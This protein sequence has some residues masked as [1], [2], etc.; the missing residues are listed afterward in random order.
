LQILTGHTDSITV[1]SIT[2]DGQRA[3]T[4]SSDKT[5]VLWDLG[6]GKKLACFIS[7]SFICIVKIY[8]KGL[9]LGYSSGE[10]V[11]L[12]ADKN[13]FCYGT[14]ITTARQIWDFELQKY[15]KLSAD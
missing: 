8:L 10:V 5:C 6:T 1:I 7:D 11:I 15:Q 12:N 4:G 14:A 13:L 3:I 9:L 2:P